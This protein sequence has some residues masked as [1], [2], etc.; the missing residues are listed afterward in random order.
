MRKEGL[1]TYLLTVLRPTAITLITSNYP[2]SP[3]GGRG[4][5]S[6]VTYLVLLTVLTRDVVVV[7]LAWT[8]LDFLPTNPQTRSTRMSNARRW[9]S[10]GGWSTAI[11]EKSVVPVTGGLSRSGEPM[12][13]IHMSPPQTRRS[14]GG[15]LVQTTGRSR[16]TTVG[17]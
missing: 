4:C 1:L 17:G 13:R 5:M 6:L 10:V 2:I 8:D 3:G 15:Q 12:S 14:T 11:C 7:G 16:L 9:F